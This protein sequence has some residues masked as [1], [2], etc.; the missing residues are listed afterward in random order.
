MFH[1]RSKWMAVLALT[2]AAATSAHADP[3]SDQAAIRDRLQRW[4]S[5]FNARDAGGAC[6]IFAPDLSYAIPGM[7]RGTRESICA[8]LSTA[9]RNSDLRLHYDNPDIHEIMMSGDIAIVRL[10]WTLTAQK[11]AE[12]EVT[13]EEGMDVFRR[14]P[15]GRWSIARFM[16]FAMQPSNLLR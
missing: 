14:Q 7:I 11:G 13:S 8:D 6:D 16:S 1:H 15:D 9:L 2:L 4:T 10:G 5:A 12:K 3:S